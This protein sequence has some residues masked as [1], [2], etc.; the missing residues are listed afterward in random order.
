ME[1]ITKKET[2]K[3]AFDIKNDADKVVLNFSKYKIEPHK[4][5]SLN[6]LLKAMYG[7]ELPSEYLIFSDNPIID[8]NWKYDEID[9]MSLMMILPSLLS[10]YEYILFNTALDIIFK[11]VV[12]P[13]L[14]NNKN[15]KEFNII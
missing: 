10:E 1:D 11:E 5:Y 6:G 4:K 8:L 2:E 3:I 15:I 13:N 14:E 12:E 7:E 9:H